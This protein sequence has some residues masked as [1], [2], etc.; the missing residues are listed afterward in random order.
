MNNDMARKLNN[1]IDVRRMNGTDSNAI[2]KK[3][4]QKS[5]FSNINMPADSF[6]QAKS[7]PI[8]N[9]NQTAQ[10]VSD[11][12]MES[13]QK[14]LENPEYAESYIHFCDSLTADGM[15]LR[16]AIDKTDKVFSA[17]K[18]KKIYE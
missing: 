13:V 6:V 8:K 12:V 4:A 17:L 7:A 16:E 3:A 14:F 2:Q 5:N 10:Y 1:H 11:S 9:E 18:N 15:E